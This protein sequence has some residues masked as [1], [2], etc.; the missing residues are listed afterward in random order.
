MDH[1]LELQ[2]YNVSRETISNLEKYVDLL[3][4][5]NEHIN[6]VSRNSL[7]DV[8]FRHVLDSAQLINYLEVNTKKIIDIGS[9]AG[10]PAMVMAI[11]LKESRPQTEIHLTESIRKKTMFLNAVREELKL[12]NIFIHNQRIENI[13]FKNVDVITAR[14]VSAL[15]TL[16][17][18]AYKICN[19]NTKMLFL[20]GKNYVQECESA[21]QHWQFDEIIH[22][23][24][25]S[26]DGVIM[27]LFNLRKK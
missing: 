15:D 25:Y 13:V 1:I 18:Y 6:L 23:N 21:K 24:Q 5:W 22:K 10:F 2:K 26:E 3:Q 20:K 16:C 9:G 14:A 8:W 27:E 11:L 7:A 4:E 19:N 12:D 17:A